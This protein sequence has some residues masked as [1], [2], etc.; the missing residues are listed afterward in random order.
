MKEILRPK[1]WAGP[2]MIG[3]FVVMA[4]TGILMFLHLNIGAMKLAHEWL[5]CFLSPEANTPQPVRFTNV[6]QILEKTV[7]E[8]K[9]K[10][11]IAQL[12]TPK[13][14]RP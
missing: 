12:T 7:F 8:N 11:A 6:D 5:S 2:L 9:I 13:Q 10:K 1:T 4:V 14:Q 3:S